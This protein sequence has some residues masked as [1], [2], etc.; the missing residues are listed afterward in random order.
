MRFFDVKGGGV[1]TGEAVAVET[2]VDWLS[3]WGNCKEN[4]RF[5]DLFR[6]RI[7]TVVA[8]TLERKVKMRGY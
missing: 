6:A 4:S 7:S 8:R 2:K 1:F 5:K 3:N